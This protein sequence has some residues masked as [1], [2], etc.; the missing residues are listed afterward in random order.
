MLHPIL[1]RME[2][3]GYAVF[4]EG[5]YNLNIVGI[6]KRGGVV[7]LWNDQIH[8]LFKVNGEWRDLWW[9]ATTSPGKHYLVSKSK[10][11]NPAGTAILVPGQYRGAYR[12]A[13]H[14]KSRYEALCQRGP[15]RVARDNDQDGAW[16]YDAPQESG[17]Y[18]INLHASSSSPYTRDQVRDSVGVWS[19]GCQVW[20]STAA[21]RSFMKLCRLQRKERGWE[22]FTYTLLNEWTP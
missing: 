4:T 6:R 9:E 11:L 3:L 17:L 16:D 10:Q 2:G 15:V 14:G 21:F 1:A 5:D 8:C 7:D 13:R 18:G 19:G 22:S 12:I 20:R